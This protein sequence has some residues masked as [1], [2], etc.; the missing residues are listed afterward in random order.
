MLSNLQ[1][2][3]FVSFGNFDL[4]G[5]QNF[6]EFLV[7]FDIHDGT[8]NGGDLTAKGGNGGAVSTDTRCELDSS[9]M[10]KTRA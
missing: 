5:V 10:G 8:D 1:D 7:E 3:S 4:E 2:Q 9:G 6:R